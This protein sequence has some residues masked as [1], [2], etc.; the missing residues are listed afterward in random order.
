MQEL[1]PHRQLL[2]SLFASLSWSELTEKDVPRARDSSLPLLTL[3]VLFPGAV[4]PALDLLDRN[5][6]ARIYAPTDPSSERPY[7]SASLHKQSG[8]DSSVRHLNR[9]RKLFFP[10]SELSME[11]KPSTRFYLVHPAASTSSCHRDRAPRRSVKVYAVHLDSWS[12]S[13]PGFA[14]E[15]FAGHVQLAD[16]EQNYLIPATPQL[17]S[18]SFGS[19]TSRKAG[20]EDKNLDFGGL[21][22]GGLPISRGDVPCCKH[23]MACLLAETWPCMLGTEDYCRNT[24]KLEVAGNISRI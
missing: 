14:L 12:C 3:H 18:P 20:Q 21:H 5:L 17:S 4:L 15:A 23:L 10:V 19:P 6:V 16:D 11:Q 7:P 2:T 13:C 8:L 1:P 24:T 22:V 9:D